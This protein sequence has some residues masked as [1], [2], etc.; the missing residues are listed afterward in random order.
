MTKSSM[1]TYD[2]CVSHKLEL[3]NLLG[4]DVQVLDRFIV[5]ARLC[6]HHQ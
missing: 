5:G 6:L 4:R 1:G 2:G 3:A